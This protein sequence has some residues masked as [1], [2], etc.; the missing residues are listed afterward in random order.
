M[1]IPP[2]YLFPMNVFFIASEASPLAKTGGLADVIGAL[3]QA[4]HAYKHKLTVIMPYYRQIIDATDVNI[5]PIKK[6]ISIWADGINRNCPIHQLHLA[7]VTFLLVEQDDLYNRKGLYG[8]T[9]SEYEDNFLRFVLFNRVALELAAQSS[10]NVDILHCHDWQTGLI[11]LLLRSQ[12]GHFPKLG[13]TKTVFTIHNLAYQGI[14]PAEWMR[15]MGIPTQH[16]H[17]DGFEFYGQINCMKAGIMMADAITTVSETYAKEILTPE[18]G[19]HLDGFLIRHQSKLSGIVNGIDIN[20]WDPANDPLI[21]HT[22]STKNIAGKKKCK[23]ALQAFC[24]FPLSESTPLLTLISR[25]AEQKGIGLLLPNIEAWMNRG[26][27]LVILGSGDPDIEKSLKKF[28][29]KYP[30]N[31]FFMSDFNEPLAH[32]IY[33]GGDIFLMPSLF[34]PCG[35]GQLIAMR[36]GNVPVVRSTGGLCDTVTDYNVSKKQATGV[37][38]SNA[39]AKALN[40]AVN[41]TITLFQKPAVWSR[42]RNNALRRDSSWDRS[43][44]LYAR[45]YTDLIKPKNLG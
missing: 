40:D 8:T 1:T 11:P 41:E 21:P 5:T 28:A 25:L 14:F 24:G 29:T 15:R 19:C 18:Y 2:K 38:F 30:D 10:E 16:F 27:Q 32:K 6:S 31:L 4:L 17:H 42:I 45:L 23:L 12:Y 37:H 3:P 43:S 13:Q 44:L 35:L 39:T 20:V 22:F 9:D 34:E 33:A 36:Y 7:G 26:M